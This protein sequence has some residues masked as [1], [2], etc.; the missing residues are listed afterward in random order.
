MRP[1]LKTL[2]VI[3]L[4][5]IT[6]CGNDDT[7]G[8]GAASIDHEHDTQD[9]SCTV[10]DHGNGTATMTCDDGTVQS[11]PTSIPA[12]MAFIPG[13]AFMMGCNEEVEYP[14]EMFDDPKERKARTC[15][16][17]EYPQHEVTLTPYFMDIY[18]TTAAEYTGCV[19][20]GYCTP[21]LSGEDILEMYGETAASIAGK[22]SYANPERINHPI[23]HITWQQAV[24]YCAWQDK[25]LPTEA[26][27]EL[28]ARGYDGRKYPWGNDPLTCELTH[29]HNLDTDTANCFRYEAVAVGSMPGDRSPFGIYDMAGN[30]TE[31]LLDWCQQDYYSQTPDDGWFDPTGPVIEEPAESDVRCTRGGSFAFAVDGYPINIA[32]SGS[33]SSSLPDYN[34]VPDIGIRCAR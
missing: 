2:L 19:N 4:A 23:N 13:G 28:A 30:V 1:A 17:V 14:Q 20:A 16:P 31:W 25:K 12:G 15:H 11:F 21:A 7:L 32:R 10:T 26:Q 24:D 5:L 33:R 34:I 29:V 6:A 18:E 27:W 22:A 9:N 8:D 3:V